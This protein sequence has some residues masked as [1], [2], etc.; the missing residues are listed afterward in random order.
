MRLRDPKTLPSVQLAEVV[1]QIQSVLW[2]REV[3]DF[4]VLIEEDAP[5]DSSTADEVARILC[6]FGLGPKP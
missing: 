2:R 6:A 1:D 5:W 3:D 4:V